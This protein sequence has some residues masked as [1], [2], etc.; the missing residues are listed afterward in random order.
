MHRQ[1]PHIG[2]VERRDIFHAEVDTGGH[3]RSG[4]VVRGRVIMYVIETDTHGIVGHAGV[5]RVCHGNSQSRERSGTGELD[6]SIHHGASAT[7]NW[8]KKPRAAAVQNGA[9]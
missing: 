3:I 6:R 2:E 1:P 8:L 9:T 4:K 7:K 5:V